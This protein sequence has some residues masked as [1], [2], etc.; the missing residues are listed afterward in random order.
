MPELETISLLF[1]NDN[2]QTYLSGTLPSI[3][4]SKRERKFPKKFH[5]NVHNVT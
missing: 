3:Q 4:L 2:K 5:D 1:S